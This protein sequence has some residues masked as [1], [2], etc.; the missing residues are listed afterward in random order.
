MRAIKR[1]PLSL[2]LAS[3]LGLASAHTASAEPL[4][5]QFQYAYGESETTRSAGVG[6]A[7]RALGNGTTALFQN[8][9]NLAAA[10]LYHVE[11]SAQFSPETGRQ[12]YAG[13]ITDSVTSR[14]AGG[15]SVGGGFLTGTG[16]P[17]LL[18]RTLFDAR[19]AIGYPVSDSVLVGFG[20]R[21]TKI[22]Q[23]GIGGPFGASKV[24]GGLVDPG[25]GDESIRTKMVNAGALDVGLTIRATDAFHVAAVAQNVSFTS[26]ALLP[27][28]L[29]GGAGFGTGDFSLEVDGLADLSSYSKTSARVMAG[30]EYLLADRM[31]LR[32]G[33]RFDSGAERHAFSLGAGYASPQFSIEA[34][35]RRTIGEPAVT[36]IVL[37]VAYFLEASGLT[38]TPADM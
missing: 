13:T 12:Y 27:T 34:S 16:T 18:D 36:T 6:G 15:F 20:S 4:P 7:M 35:A 28:L 33:Y 8:P 11:G 24:S 19:A 30:A 21:F 23:G 31:P 5:A 14:V 37:G 10:Q 26:N 29:G 1:R 38:R 3:A 25:R 22:T 17:A 9:A 32:A 2:C